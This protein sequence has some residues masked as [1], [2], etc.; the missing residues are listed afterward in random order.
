MAFLWLFPH[1]ICI[2]DDKTKCQICITF[3]PIPLCIQGLATETKKAN[4]MSFSC[5]QEGIGIILPSVGKHTW[6][7]LVQLIKSVLWYYCYTSYMYSLL[8]SF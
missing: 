2:V 5:T 6:Y 7:L 3:S 8:H 1:R 4:E